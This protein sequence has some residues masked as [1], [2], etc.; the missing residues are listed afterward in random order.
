MDRHRATQDKQRKMELVKGEAADMFL[1]FTK[2][3]QEA[4]AGA[5]TIHHI[6]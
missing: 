4:R 2:V 3:D 1:I 5:P 6:C